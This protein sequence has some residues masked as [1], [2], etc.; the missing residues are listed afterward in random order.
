VSDTRDC[1]GFLDQ[2]EPLDRTRL[3]RVLN[4]SVWLDMYHPEIIF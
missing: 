2:P 4:L 1:A 3:E